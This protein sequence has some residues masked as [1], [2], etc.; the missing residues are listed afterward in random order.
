[1]ASSSWRPWRR[2][3]PPST[4][5]RR[6][7]RAPLALVLLV[8]LAAIG[9]RLT[10]G[11]SWADCYWMVAIT[12]STIG[13]G[14]VQ[15]LSPAGRVVTALLILGGVVVVQISIQ[16]VLGL[17]ESGYFRR[18]RE[19]RFRRWLKTMQNH[20]IL[21]GYGRIGREIAEQLT[22]ERVPL[23]VVEMD[24]ERRDAAEDRGLPVLV[25]DAT[26]DETLLEAGIHHCRSLVAALPSNAAN[27]YVVL[28]AR[29]LAPNCRLIAR[30]D[31]DEAERK[32]RLAGADQVV[33][34]YVS[35]GRMMAATAL[36]PL[37]VTFMDLL[38]GS[39]CEVEEFRLSSDPQ[40]LGRLLGMSL[41]EL[42]LG[43]RTGALVLAVQ[44]APLASEAMRQYRGASYVREQQTLIA[45]PGSEHR[46]APGQMLVVMGSK[47]QLE[48]VTSL[49]GEALS[50]VDHM[51]G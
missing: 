45:N 17:S 50:S 11:W 49:L 48:G 25:A 47:G 34:P 15:P 46:L 23:L 35:G 43:R 32:L 37:A 16:G 3:R 21:C 5:I 38:A 39:D 2:R 13:Y 14:E 30:S 1:M 7:W 22:R 10:E 44:P 42:Q 24:Q 4:R 31:S 20:V 12:I 40:A 36:R 28:S 9:Y 18:L 26:L 8:N 29:G 41:G 33:S 51:A 19:R 27:L 6:P